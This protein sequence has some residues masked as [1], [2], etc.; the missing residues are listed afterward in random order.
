MLLD[1]QNVVIIIIIYKNK[2]FTLKHLFDLTEKLENWTQ[3]KVVAI[4]IKLFAL[5]YII[6]QYWNIKLNV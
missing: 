2:S 1:L 5:I 3:K 4:V 6:I